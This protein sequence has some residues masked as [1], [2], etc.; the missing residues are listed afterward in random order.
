MVHAQRSSLAPA[1][2][3]TSLAAVLERADLFIYGTTRATNAIVTGNIEDFLI[4]D[5]YIKE[6]SVNILV[7]GTL[8]NTMDNVRIRRN[9]ILD[10]MGTTHS[11]AI[12]AS[13]IDGLTI[14]GNIIDRNGWDHRVGRSD[15]TIFAHNCYIQR[16]VFGLVFK[17][18]VIMRAASHGLQARMGGIIEGNIFYQNPMAIMFGNEGVKF[19]EYAV[20]GSIKHNVI[21]EGIDINSNLI[22][23]AGLVLQHTASVEVTDNIFSKNLNEPGSVYGISIDGP[24]TAP[25]RNALISNNIFHDWD[26]PFRVHDYNAVSVTFKDNILYH[27]DDDKPLIRHRRS[28]TVGNVDYINNHYMRAGNQEWFKLGS[29]EIDLS[30]W[31]NDHAQ[32]AQ[33]LD[34]AFADGSRTL[35]TYARSIGLD[36]AQALIAEMRDMRKGDWDERMTPEAISAYFREGFAVVGVTN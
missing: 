31:R 16:S 21:L 22:R 8:G 29:L 13:H 34:G 20:E 17:D 24:N 18:N 10:A 33:Q 32:N 9:I 23:G 15:A 30:Q 14:E 5:C 4:E 28:Q 11:Q 7:Q 35:D 36:N 2:H 25:V 6:Y 3:S 12:Y 1:Q 27:S 26:L 19:N